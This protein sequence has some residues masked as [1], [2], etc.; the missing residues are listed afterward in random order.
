[1]DLIGTRFGH[2]I[3]VGAWVPAVTRVISGSLNLEFLDSVR[4]G[5][6]DASIQ[7]VIESL[8]VAG[9]VVDGDAVHLKVVFFRTGAVHTH[10][11]RTAPE[12]GAIADIHSHTS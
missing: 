7:S 5:N 4:V 12:T 3:H 6:R 10:I 1:M 2:D 11:L 8:V 9:C